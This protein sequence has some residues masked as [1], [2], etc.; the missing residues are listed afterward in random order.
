MSV[1]TEDLIK[2]YLDGSF[3]RILSDGKSDTL[4]VDPD[5]I[6][7]HVP[8]GGR[9]KGIK[10]PPLK[11]WTQEEEI[12]LYELRK[13]KLSRGAI[14]D[15]LCRSEECIRRKLYGQKSKRHATV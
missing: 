8:T 14:A 13:R 11:P 3:T 2:S 12:M 10:R 15:Y 6:P 9:D 4:F 1:W 5:F 7:T